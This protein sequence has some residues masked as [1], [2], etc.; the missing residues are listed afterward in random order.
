MIEKDDL[1]EKIFRNSENYFNGE[2]NCH[3]KSAV[4]TCPK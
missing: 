2:R 3:S 4:R 1:R